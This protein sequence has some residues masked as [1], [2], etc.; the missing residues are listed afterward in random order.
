MMAA[1]LSVRLRALPTCRGFACTM[2]DTPSSSSP[3]ASGGPE[4]TF[5]RAVVTGLNRLMTHA[6]YR[7]GLS[8]SNR[9]ILR[10]RLPGATGPGTGAQ[11]PDRRAAR[12]RIELRRHDDPDFRGR[13]IGDRALRVPIAAVA[14]HPLRL[15]PDLNGLLVL[16]VLLV[17]GDGFSFDH[18]RLYSAAVVH[19]QPDFGIS[20]ERSRQVDDDAVLADDAEVKQSAELRRED[21]ADRQ[22]LGQPQRERRERE[23]ADSDPD[24]RAAVE[25]EPIGIERRLDLVVEDVVLGAVVFVVEPAARGELFGG[26]VNRDVA[27]A[28]PIEERDVLRVLAR[29][30]VGQ[31]AELARA[32]FRNEVAGRRRQRPAFA[33]EVGEVEVQCSTDVLVEDVLR[34]SQVALRDGARDER[35]LAESPVEVARAHADERG[36]EVSL[37]I[38]VTREDAELRLF[39]DVARGE[40]H[41]ASAQQHDGCHPVSSF[42][43]EC[44]AHRQ[45]DRQI[46]TADGQVANVEL[47]VRG[48][49]EAVQTGNVGQPFDGGDG[50]SLRRAARRAGDVHLPGTDGRLVPAL[51]EDLEQQ[52]FR[53]VLER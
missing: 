29:A 20:D 35:S 40:V 39:G 26:G 11:G 31:A 33:T 2:S 49:P 34:L 5:N 43:D 53:S 8:D 30:G 41:L 12:Q 48:E 3:S 1:V 27:P 45:L 36:I 16:L 44:G 52:T 25:P 51:H 6:K 32:D 22:R 18:L 21:A 14:V 46:R 37:E 10:G 50:P 17:D 9:N 24:R 42:G 7:A 15:E 28:P 23:R 38:R 4:D 19:L 13:V 47:L